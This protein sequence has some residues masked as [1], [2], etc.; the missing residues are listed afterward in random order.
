M[1]NVRE[2]AIELLNSLI[3]GFERERNVI[4]GVVGS[5]GGDTE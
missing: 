4:G 1:F 2:S 5:G 3:D